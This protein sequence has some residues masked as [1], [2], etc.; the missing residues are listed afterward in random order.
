MINWK[1]QTHYDGEYVSYEDLILKRVPREDKH[2]Y[3][4]PNHKYDIDP[5]CYYNMEKGVKIFNDVL[6][7]NK[8]ITILVDVDVDG[9]TSASMLRMAIK[10]HSTCDVNIVHHKTKK[11]G[12]YDE[13]IDEIMKTEPMLLIIP[14]AASNDIE[15]IWNLGK[16]MDVIVI[17]HHD[18][19]N[20]RYYD[21]DIDIQHG[22]CLINNQAK[23]NKDSNPHLT[24]SGLTLRFLQE[25][26][27]FRGYDM[28]YKYYDLA[29]MGLIG[30]MADYSD[31][32][33]RNIVFKGLENINNELLKVALK[34]K[35]PHV[36]KYE[37]M[38]IAF[39]FNPFI[40]AITRMATMEEKEMVFNALSDNYI[41]ATH[42]VPKRRK[43][44]GK[45]QLVNITQTRY[46]YVYDIMSRVKGKQDRTV[47]KLEE[48]LYGDISNHGGVA[49]GL[50]DEEFRGITGL[51]ANRVA[52][53]LKKPTLLLRKKQ[54]DSELS[55]SARGYT[56]VLDDFK[57]WC[58]D[59]ELFHLAEGHDNAFGIKIYEHYIDDLINQSKVVKKQDKTYH[60][61]IIFNDFNRVTRDDI[62]TLNKLTYL[63]G[64]SVDQLKLSLNNYTVDKDNV[65]SF[66]SVTKINTKEGVE[67]IIF[68][69]NGATVDLL[70][71]TMGNEIQI[72][73][74][75]IPS[76]NVWFNKT[77]P[78]IIVD[79]IQIHRENNII[80]EQP[81]KIN[82][83]IF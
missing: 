29:M 57:T 48:E 5:R 34:D 36:Y 70:N 24:G 55:G 21:K 17:D 51:V 30:D 56:R 81:R 9:Y 22:L 46:E 10:A 32:E 69:D 78:Q 11:H 28:G 19:S 27:R 12:L 33:I 35:I 20:E 1:V 25:F 37:P 16:Y 75:G 73:V 45:M 79:D 43:I 13:V 23:W 4:Y 50:I 61:D 74:V 6:K 41:N 58:Q 44:R 3:K 64:G 76:I 49:I 63:T 14:D 71:K 26:Y 65:K 72:D 15:E 77:T 18:I 67:L 68:N 80:G 40:N 7:T 38:D 47:K 42:N 59:T 8:N 2:S 60:V 54:G 52:S 31:L 66:N 83:P 39:N 62:M 53:N 82:K